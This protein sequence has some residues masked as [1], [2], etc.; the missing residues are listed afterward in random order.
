ME[1]HTEG[2]AVSKTQ[3]YL[4]PLPAH[5]CNTPPSSAGL[6]VAGSSLE[7]TFCMLC[8]LR[9]PACQEEVLTGATYHM[10]V[11]MNTLSLSLSI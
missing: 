5:N 9:Q 6:F 10:D 3:S 1:A 4:R 2:E 8:T 7:P 11:E